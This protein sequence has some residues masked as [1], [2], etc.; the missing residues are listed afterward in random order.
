MWKESK[1]YVNIGAIVVSA[2]MAFGLLVPEEGAAASAS[3]AQ[4]IGGV[5][6]LVTVVSM[7]RARKKG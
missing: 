4:I 5:F 2:L 6:G 7:V 3:V 1:T